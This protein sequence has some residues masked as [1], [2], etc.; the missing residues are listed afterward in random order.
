M[1]TNT[2]A[3]DAPTTDTNDG[4]FIDSLDAYFNNP[5]G[6]DLTPAADPVAAHRAAVR[7]LAIGQGHKGRRPAAA[8][9]LSARQKDDAKRRLLSRL[10]YCL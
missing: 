1:D 10:F 2:P 4:G 7:A 6:P 5:S 8:A 3:A 9:P